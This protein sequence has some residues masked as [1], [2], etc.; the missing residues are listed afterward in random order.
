MCIAAN[1]AVS[2]KM[3]MFTDADFMDM[4]RGIY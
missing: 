4:A 2:N 3:T 1:N